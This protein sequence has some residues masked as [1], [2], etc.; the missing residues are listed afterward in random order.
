[1]EINRQSPKNRLVLVVVRLLVP[2]LAQEGEVCRFRL[3]WDAPQAEGR[4]QVRLGLRLPVAGAATWD[5]L[6]AN[7]EVQERTVL[8]LIA[9][10]K[11]EATRS[12]ERGDGE[13]AARWVEEAKRLLAAASATPEVRREAQAL[14]D[15]EAHLKSGDWVKFWKHAKFQAYQRRHSKPYP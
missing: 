2:P 13:G 5:N 12:L 6:A 1:V 8:L 10:C 3:S 7:V 4:Q 9:R 14:A 11:K 15:I